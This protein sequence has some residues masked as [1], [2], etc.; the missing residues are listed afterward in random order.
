MTTLCGLLAD[1]VC[2]G[3]SAPDKSSIACTGS[4]HYGAIEVLC[5]CECHVVQVV[6]GI[7]RVARGGVEPPISGL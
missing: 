6:N 3:H 5:D 2:T 7:Y 4:Q 1:Y